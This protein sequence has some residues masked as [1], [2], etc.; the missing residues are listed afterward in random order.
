MFFDLGV[1]MYVIARWWFFCFNHTE[2]ML[3]GNLG[4]FS[5]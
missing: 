5:F 4:L 3:D 1:Y 2:E